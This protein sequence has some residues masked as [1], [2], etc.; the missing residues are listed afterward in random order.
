M[1]TFMKHAL[2]RLNEGSDGHGDMVFRSLD[3][4][5]EFV[6]DWQLAKYLW[7]IPYV[8]KPL[9]VAAGAVE[10][11]RVAHHFFTGKELTPD[12]LTAANSDLARL[13]ISPET[14]V[15]ELSDGQ[16]TQIIEAAKP[17]AASAADA[18]KLAAFYNSAIGRMVLSNYHENIVQA[19]TQLD[20]LGAGLG[21]NRREAARVVLALRTLLGMDPMFIGLAT[22]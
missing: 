3:E 20:E 12:Q 5:A 19:R 10:I 15:R 11:Y 18:A 8:G 13:H 22:E 16:R 1:D 17:P 4:L 6:G 21:V 2:D 9:A 7:R 14:P